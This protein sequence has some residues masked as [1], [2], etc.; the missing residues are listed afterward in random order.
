MTD[1]KI[2]SHPK[3]VCNSTDSVPFIFQIHEERENEIVSTK[4][5][6]KVGEQGRK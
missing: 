5:Q 6:G 1:P 4:A 3:I 2:L